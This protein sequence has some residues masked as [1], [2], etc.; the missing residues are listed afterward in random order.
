MWGK[1]ET[2]REMGRCGV[3]KR[4]LPHEEFVERVGAIVGTSVTRGAS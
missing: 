1:V 2:E 3:E 4:T